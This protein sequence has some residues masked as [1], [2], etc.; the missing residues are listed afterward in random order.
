MNVGVALEE[1]DLASG[2]TTTLSELAAQALRAESLGYS[3][4][5]VMDHFWIQG[6]AGRRGA[7]EPLVTLAYL[8]ART[9][10]IKLGTLVLCNSLRHPGQ[11]AREGAAL[12]DAA[13]GRIILGL[14]AGWHAPE[15][16]AF[17]VPFDHRVSRLEETL[18]ALPS[19]LAGQSVDLVGEHL[20]LTGAEVLTSAPAPPLWV[21]AAGPRSIG[22]AA[23]YADGWNL[24]WLGPEPSPFAGSL[25]RLREETARARRPPGAV[26]ASVGLLAFPIEGEEREAVLSRAA[27]LPRGRWDP[28]RAD[29]QAVIGPPA[30]L[31]EVLRA[32]REAGAEHV[33]LS[34]AP[35]PFGGF[36]GAY[37][38]RAAPALE[39]L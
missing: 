20:R 10:R 35:S 24:A 34:F 8:A 4:A 12:A 6:A 22:L 13:P 2:R 28:A 26:T 5:W 23:R 21:A 36:D 19:L 29:E 27:S 32:Y 18:L 33:I 25:S 9:S 31:A 37:V 3:S 38:E 1:F 16:E 15:Y 14:G 30:R 17:G 39:M 7:H 11:L